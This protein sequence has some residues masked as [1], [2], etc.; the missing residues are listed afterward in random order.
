MAFANAGRVTLRAADSIG[1]S[2]AFL[3]TDLRSAFRSRKSVTVLGHNALKLGS[4]CRYRLIFGER[5]KAAQ[6]GRYSRLDLDGR[7]IEV[8]ALLTFSDVPAN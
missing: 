3:A 1:R 2:T 4:N 8:V 5:K 6:M 7:S